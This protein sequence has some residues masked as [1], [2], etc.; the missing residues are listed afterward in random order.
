[1]WPLALAAVA[2]ALGIGIPVAMKLRSRPAPPSRPWTALVPDVNGVIAVL[3]FTDFALAVSVQSPQAPLIVD[4]IQKSIAGHEV[5]GTAYNPGTP[6]PADWPDAHLDPTRDDPA[7][8][9]FRGRTNDIIRISAGV[10]G[11]NV[12]F[13]VRVFT[14]APIPTLAGFS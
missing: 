13:P 12:A 6:D 8:Y 2:A 10:Y 3:P 5:E 11:P 4:S 7:Y 1:M 9:R 14:E